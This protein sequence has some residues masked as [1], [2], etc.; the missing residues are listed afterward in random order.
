MLDQI[1][2]QSFHETELGKLISRAD[3]FGLRA[4]L[5]L[6]EINNLLNRFDQLHD[7]WKTHPITK[8]FLLALKVERMTQLGICVNNATTEMSEVALRSRLSAANQTN[9][10]ETYANK[11]ISVS[12]IV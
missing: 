11:S 5:S 1:D 12:C 7:N 2:K 4:E 3:E 9:K 10:I 6:E 8:V